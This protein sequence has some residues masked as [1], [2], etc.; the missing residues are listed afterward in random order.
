[1][2]GRTITWVDSN[3]FFRT[4]IGE[5]VIFPL[6]NFTCI[7]LIKYAILCNHTIVLQRR[8]HIHMFMFCCQTLTPSWCNNNKLSWAK[9]QTIY[10]RKLFI[11]HKLTSKQI[12]AS[13]SFFLINK[14]LHRHL[15]NP[16][17]KSC[18]HLVRIYLDPMKFNWGLGV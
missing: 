17:T 1:M 7:N 3:L 15:I 13:Y 5:N 18:R 12:I 10:F 11:Y 16:A 4:W 6:L 14:T 8:T 9:F 2:C